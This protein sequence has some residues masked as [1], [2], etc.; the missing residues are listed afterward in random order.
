MAHSR[1]AQGRVLCEVGGRLVVPVSVAAD[2]ECLYVVDRFGE[3]QDASLRLHVYDRRG[4]G[5]AVGYVLARSTLLSKVGLGAVHSVVCVPTV[6]RQP[7][8][9]GSGRTPPAAAAS[10]AAAASDRAAAVA[11]R[12]PAS[13]LVLASGNGA[14]A[15]DARTGR[16]LCTLVEE[17]YV[18]GLC[19]LAPGRVAVSFAHRG[20]TELQVFSLPT[21]QQT[22]VITLATHKRDIACPTA[23]LASA[24][25]ASHHELFALEKRAVTVGDLRCEA[26]TF[27]AA[28]HDRSVLPFC[29]PLTATRWLGRW[30]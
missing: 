14:T 26:G 25:A 10:A 18:T 5:H 29:T 2:E 19:A 16:V 11:A 23:H 4:D 21:G 13:W 27:A 1:A 28:L 3:G 30:P 8:G 9:A 6:A 12:P 20:K 22:H 17:R 24:A 7:A 15:L